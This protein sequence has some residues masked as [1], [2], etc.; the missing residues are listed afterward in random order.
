M[1]QLDNRFPAI[2]AVIILTALSGCIGDNASGWSMT[3]NGDH[4]MSIDSAIYQKM[5]NCSVAYNGVSDIPPGGGIP[6]EIFLAYY[7]VYP[8]TSVTYGGTTYDWKSA[9]YSSDKDDMPLVT[10]NGSLYFQ[11]RWARA[12]N[13]NVTVTDKMNITTLDVAPSVLYALGAGGK[14]DILANNTS[15]VVLV[16]IDAFG[17]QRYVSSTRVGIVDN[18]SAI[19]PP[20]KAMAE[21]PSISQVNSKAMVTGL[22]PDLSK[23]SFRSY[24]PDGETMIDA[25]NRQGKKAVWVD[26]SSAP[27]KIDGTILN[28]DKNGDGSA[29]DDA[30]D[31]AIAQ[32]RAGADLVIVHFDSTDTTMHQ[33]GP[34]SPQAEAA[35]KRADAMVGRIESSLSK[36]T[37]LIVWADHGCHPTK[38][39]GDHGTLIPDDMYIPIFIRYV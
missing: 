28:D 36:G 9:A 2:L 20:I 1:A 19:G 3:V 5:A 11:G 23:G 13:I 35:V 24:I 16:Y 22:A 6:L 32:Y 21:Y 18:L 33:M 15:R 26:G 29:D 8:L 27:V 7:G 39:G 4:S 25:V 31:A 38:D 37:V 34:D 17:Y 14:E 10:S 12:D 30:A